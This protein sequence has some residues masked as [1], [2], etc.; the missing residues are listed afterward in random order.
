MSEIKLISLETGDRVQVR[1]KTMLS[2]QEAE[3]IKV[4]KRTVRIKLLGNQERLIH[5]KYV[6]SKIRR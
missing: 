4:F 3:V 5:R 6:L 2:P 1:D